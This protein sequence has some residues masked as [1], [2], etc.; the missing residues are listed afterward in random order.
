[1]NNVTCASCYVYE[2]FAA[3]CVMPRKSQFVVLETVHM[4]SLN[5]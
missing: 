3:S 1:M 2:I 4:T 5:F